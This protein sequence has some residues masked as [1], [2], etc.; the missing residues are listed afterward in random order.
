MR[1]IVGSSLRFPFLVV[2]AAAALLFFGAEQLGH[3]KVDVFPEF[4]PTQV[5]SQ[6]ACLGLAA[7]EVEQLV[8]VRREDAL[9]GVSGVQT[10]RSESAAERSSIVLLFRSGTDLFQARQLVV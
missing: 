10:I 6:T 8:A 3:E 4:A 9:Q 2:A 5:Q 1:W 7:S